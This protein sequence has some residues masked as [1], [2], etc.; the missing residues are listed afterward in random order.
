MKTLACAALLFALEAAAPTKILAQSAEVSGALL[1]GLD[2]ITA[3][4]TTFEAP[5]EREARFGTLRI[6]AHA[7]RKRPPEET[8][9]VAVFLEIEEV[10]P[11]VDGRLPLFSGWMF[12]SSPALSA[13]EHPVYD[14]WVIDCRT[15]ADDSDLPERLKSPNLDR[16]PDDAPDNAA[17]KRE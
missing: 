10:R 13:L 17:D 4:I 15:V 8:P 16:V 6:V 14:V 3:R 12:A 1:R 7:C 2:K 9:E 5:L 11:G